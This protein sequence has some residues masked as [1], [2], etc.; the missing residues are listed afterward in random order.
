MGGAAGGALAFGPGRL[1]R[2]GY[3]TFLGVK[4]LRVNVA[5]ACS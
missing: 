2:S 3:V 4:K 5:D 1:D